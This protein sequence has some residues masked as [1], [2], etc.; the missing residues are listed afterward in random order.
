[1]KHLAL[2]SVLVMTAGVGLAHA[3]VNV[4]DGGTTLGLLTGAM[5]GLGVLRAFRR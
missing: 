2:A 4:P 5:L 1:M 3:S